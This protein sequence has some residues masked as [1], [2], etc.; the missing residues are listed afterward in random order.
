LLHGPGPSD[1][2]HEQPACVKYS[3]KKEDLKAFEENQKQLEVIKEF[4]RAM[5]DA[6]DAQDAKQAQP[7]EMEVSADGGVAAFGGAADEDD[8]DDM[9][10]DDSGED[11]DMKMRFQEDALFIV[12][13]SKSE[14]LFLKV[15]KMLEL[16]EKEYRYIPGVSTIYKAKHIPGTGADGEDGATLESTAFSYALET[17]NASSVWF[18]QGIAKIKQSEF[19]DEFVFNCEN[20]LKDYRPC[21]AE[22]WKAL[23]ELKAQGLVRSLGVSNFNVNHLQYFRSMAIDAGF[24]Q[25]MPAVN[26]I[27]FGPR[28]FGDKH[29][30]TQEIHAFAKEERIQLVGYGTMAGF[31]GKDKI[32]GNQKLQ[33]LAGAQK[34]GAGVTV[35][36]LLLRWSIQHGVAVIPGSGDP[37]HMAENLDVFSFSLSE[38]AM[39]QIESIAGK[40]YYYYMFGL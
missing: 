38:D 14:E 34:S 40:N 33:A 10:G 2:N 31:G 35:G 39:R 18:T 24:E 29:E 16:D 27:E 26:Q 23:E 8:D 32:L 19:S 5:R 28:G 6:R 21:W 37:S 13:G 1:K 7:K 9:G 3:T 15:L 25:V 17:T 12:R 11:A 22:T 30:A 36:Q 20:R 4:E